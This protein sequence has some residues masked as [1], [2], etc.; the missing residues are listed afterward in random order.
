MTVYEISRA[1]ISYTVTVI[2]TATSR[3]ALI[4][5]GA[6]FVTGVE[7]VVPVAGAVSGIYGGFATIENTTAGV[8]AGLATGNWR[9]LGAQVSSML[10]INGS[11]GGKVQGGHGGKL[12]QDI[13]KDV[14]GSVM[15]FMTT[16]VAPNPCEE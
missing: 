14:A 7:P 10:M 4:I 2:P 9:H 1:A 12:A 13:A 8:L 15:E 3:K 11:L 5:T 16:K 6:A